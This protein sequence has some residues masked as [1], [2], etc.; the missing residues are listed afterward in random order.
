M[1]ELF[2]RTLRNNMINF[3]SINYPYH[4][5]VLGHDT[6]KILT[7][8]VMIFSKWPIQKENEIEYDAGNGMDA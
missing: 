8:G 1:E 3:M 7:G 2:D 5:N 4:T 6:D